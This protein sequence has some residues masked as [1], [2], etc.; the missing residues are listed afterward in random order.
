[1]PISMTSAV[2]WK[3]SRAVAACSWR[4]VSPFLRQ[5]PLVALVAAALAAAVP[6]VA[7][8]FGR[9]L[10]AGF[11]EAVAADET[12]AHV[13][14]LDLAFSGA[15][16]GA[17]IA[18]LAPGRAFLGAQLEA[19][20]VSRLASFVALTAVPVLALGAAGCALGALFLVPLTADTPGGGAVGLVLLAGGALAAAGGAA[21]AEAVRGAVRGSGAAVLALG[22]L[23]V[24]W[25]A[26]AGVAGGGA[27]LG[28]FA[29]LVDVSRG[30]RAVPEPLLA[31]G[32]FV[33]GALA[34]WLLAAAT[35]PAGREGLRVRGAL[36]PLPRHPFG[37]ALVGGLKRYSRRPELR[38]HAAAVLAVAGLG[39]LVLVGLLSVD[40]AVAV[41]AAGG[42]GALGA[43]V[44][45]LSCGGVDR[46]A[47]WLWRSSPQ[48]RA[49]TA[50]AS[51][52]AAL[53][54]A[55]VVTAGAL[56]PATVAEHAAL[57]TYLSL[58][59]AVA[60]VFSAALLAG[61][62]VP[63]RSDRVADQVVSYAALAAATLALWLALSAAA[64]RVVAAGIPS[65]AVG[66]AVVALALACGLT[67]HAAGS[68]RR[69]T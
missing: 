56:A 9:R 61:A 40:A 37:A 23:G 54:L 49:A 63:W 38:R 59:V 45:P 32:A 22:G 68:S 24:L 33:A 5:N 4:R 15:L 25:A 52:V 43:A 14:A 42:V 57:S 48:P 41:V 67:G 13:L 7:V 46:E 69:R 47:E 17:T 44:L 1:M 19:A 16:I 6:V 18:S 64:R 26:G 8:V 51:A 55:A 35:R 31:L 53:A 10:A 39:G 60:I 3:L 20:P 65:V 66:A 36:L 50:L 58:G 30:E 29:L 27:L 2:L 34:L 28:P 62:L 11:A 12:F 21:A